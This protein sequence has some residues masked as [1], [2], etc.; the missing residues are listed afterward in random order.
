MNHQTLSILWP[1]LPLHLRLR[2]FWIYL[3]DR[4]TWPIRY[5]FRAALWTIAL[6]IALP[7]HPLSIPTAL[8]G[9]LSFAMLILP[10][11]N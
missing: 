9:G 6:L 3:Y 4:H 11:K 7:P 5:A 2:I 10:T 1:S 8:G